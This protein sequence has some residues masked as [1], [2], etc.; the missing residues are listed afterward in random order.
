MAKFILNRPDD[1]L[2][3]SRGEIIGTALKWWFVLFAGALVLRAECYVLYKSMGVDPKEITENILRSFLDKPFGKVFLFVGL[4]GPL[5]EEM[6]FRLGLSFKRK[7]VA[8]WAGFLPILLTLSL[9][10]SK[11]C[12]DI[13]PWAVIIGVCLFWLICRYTTNEQWT[14]W[15]KKFIIPAMWISTIIFGLMHMMNFSVLNLQ[16]FPY[17]FVAI[18]PQMA[19]GCALAYVRVNQ[20]FWWGVLLHCIYNQMVL[21]FAHTASNIA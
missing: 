20:G 6:L 21:L 14:N 4:Y 13:L 11:G 2:T 17:V 19:Y 7:T 15:R 3:L 10:R 5:V 1:Y 8:L 16:V 12:W 18:L 9:W